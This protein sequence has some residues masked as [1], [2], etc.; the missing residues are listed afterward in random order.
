MTRPKSTGSVSI[1]RLGLDV[2]LSIQ[3]KPSKNA[4]MYAFSLRFNYIEQHKDDYL[5][6]LSEGNNLPTTGLIYKY[7]EWTLSDEI[8]TEQQLLGLTNTTIDK[9]I[10]GVQFFEFLKA[11]IS[12]QDISS[13]EFY[14]YPLHSFYQGTNNGVTAGMYHRCID[15]S[16]TA[17]NSE[18]YTYL[19]ANAPNSGL[20]QERPE[21]NNITNGVGH[22]SSR[23]VLNMNNLRIDQSTMD[24][25]SFGQIAKNLNFACYSTLGTSGVVVNF[26]FDCQE[27]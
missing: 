3:I 2:P 8:A 1:L 15:L 4:K 13:P 16:V 12:E 6:D 26:G 18:L 14:R 10:Y 19:N 24:S 17:V 11:Q 22:V 23:S 21:Y 7:V 27:N 20:N 25:L 9:V 5:Y